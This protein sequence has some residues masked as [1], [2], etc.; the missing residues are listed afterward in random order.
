VVVLLVASIPIA[1]EVVTTTTMALG[2]RELSGRN[3][4]VSR[5][6]AIEELAG[7]NMLCSDKTGTLT[8]N[9]MVI[10]DYTPTF[11]AGLI[12]AD[13]LR[14]AALAARWNEPPKDALD[15]LVLT[16]PGTDL[17]G[18][19]AYEQLEY[20]PFD[21]HIK[22][23]E[24][25]IQAPDGSEFRVTKGAPDVLLRLLPESEQS[26]GSGDE[27]SSSGSGDALCVGARVERAVEE[28]A[29]RG[30]RSLAVARTAPDGT[31]QMLGWAL[32][33]SHCNTR[34]ALLTC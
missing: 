20:M 30:I 1:M 18:L 23:T 27:S 10:Q 25:L 2:S 4:I 3:A 28:L 17:A 24:A 11:Q 31:W 32:T 6:A 21:S 26:S 16:A 12:Q 19:D 8:L 13:I 22:R 15:T 5:L 9:K 33:H 14:Y 7:M 34:Y 29:H